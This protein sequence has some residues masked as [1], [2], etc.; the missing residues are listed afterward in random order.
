MMRRLIHALSAPSAQSEVTDAD[1]SLSDEDVIA[2]AQAAYAEVRAMV[3]HQVA[4]A[5]SL[6]TK[7]GALVTV[8]VRPPRRVSGRDA[9]SPPVLH[10]IYLAHRTA[11][12][13][14]SNQPSAICVAESWSWM[15]SPPL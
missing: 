13:S 15:S 2:N 12:R 7:A 5:A 4:T 3:D 14:R 9:T 10:A 6:D 1:H 8:V 11:R